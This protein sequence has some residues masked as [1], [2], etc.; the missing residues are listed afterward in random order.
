MSLCST[1]AFYDCIFIAIGDA[2]ALKGKFAYSKWEGDEQ[3]GA[4]TASE[5]TLQQLAD[6][7]AK[8][9]AKNGFIFLICATGKSA[10][11]MVQALQLR[12]RN[13][14]DTEVCLFII[15][16]CSCCSH[17]SLYTTLLPLM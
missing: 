2:S 9:L 17:T 13:D 15:H 8:Y 12:M 10:V 1:S 14:K 3:K 16:Q 6:L 11:E 5:D 7:N 4:N